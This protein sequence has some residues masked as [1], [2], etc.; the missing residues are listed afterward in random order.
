MSKR[1][2]ATFI[3]LLVVAAA[4]S[5]QTT[6]APTPRA[7]TAAPAT[8]A[9]P[10]DAN[11]FIAPFL[12]ADTLAVAHLD[13]A[14]ID[15]AA[16][17][18]YLKSLVDEL[19]L[20]PEAVSDKQLADARTQADTLLAR[21]KQLGGR[22]LFA[23]LSQSDL[24]PNPR[25]TAVLVKI[26]PG[27]DAKALRAFLTENLHLTEMP[28]DTQRA[29]PDPAPFD[30]RRIATLRNDVLFIG[31]R[32]P[33]E[34]LVPRIAANVQNKGPLGHPELAFKSP[35]AIIEVAATLTADDRRVVKELMPDVPQQFGG[36]STDFLT[37]EP[38]IIRAELMLPPKPASLRL[39]FERP[40]SRG[41]LDD[42]AAFLTDSRDRL[43]TSSQYA[44]FLANPAIK[45][46]AADI[47]STLKE[48]LTPAP[49]P[50]LTLEAN[51]IQTLVRLLTPSLANARGQTLRVQS[52]SNIKQLL[53]ACM[54]YANDNKD[55]LPE[56]L[57]QTVQ[58]KQV[59]AQ[60]LLNPND[61]KHRRYVYQRPAV[62]TTK[63]SHP[64]KY[65]LIWEEVDDA[66]AP[67][68]VGFADGHVE[69]VQN[70]A[71]LDALLKAAA[72]PTTPQPTPGLP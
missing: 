10:V 44:E 69:S 56:S 42:V 32:A 71:A 25:P 60:M 50:T 54:I 51:H 62:P 9:A 38:L 43:L 18:T 16:L 68:N 46:M 64:D 13:A 4:A 67:R 41:N 11:T 34:R 58:L 45:P 21:F 49:G 47:T 3:G 23:V 37:R 17:Q 72:I 26:E 61:D 14:K 30:D 22:H 52:A 31:H 65:P 12:E 29:S 70:R 48:I 35:D 55:M 15:T 57:D 39:S 27:G 40:G 53:L 8:A 6:T 5:A 2:L 59:P 20:P 28:A 36:A 66:N 19:H 33:F 1:I 24:W 7:G 63:I